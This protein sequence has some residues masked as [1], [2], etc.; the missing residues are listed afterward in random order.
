MSARY[1]SRSDL[2]SRPAGFSVAAALLAFGVIALDRAHARGSIPYPG[3]FETGSPEDARTI[4]IT[5]ATIALTVVTLLA[6]LTFVAMS[7]ANTTV[8]PRQLRAFLRDRVTQYTIATFIGSFVYCLV[9]LLFYRGGEQP[10]APHLGAFVAL[11]LALTATGLLIAYLHN[12]TRAVQPNF[13]IVRIMR[14]LSAATAHFGQARSAHSVNCALSDVVV[15]AVVA[16]FPPPSRE[17][18]AIR[19]GYVQQIVHDPLVEVASRHN[20]TIRFRVRPGHFVFVGDPIADVWEFHDAV[21]AAIDEHF[22]IGDYRTLAQDLE[23]GIDQL[24]EIAIRALSPA[25]NDTFT[26]LACI[27]WLGDAVRQ[28]ITADAG[29]PIHLDA[30]GILRVIDRPLSFDSVVTAAFTKIRQSGATNAAVL[31]RLLEAV[32]RLAAHC[33]ATQRVPLLAELEATATLGRATGTPEID[34]ATIARR[35]QSAREA[36]GRSALN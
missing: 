11:L 24:V 17:V 16:G 9:V 3:I 18:F 31:L 36:L 22:D 28:F 30:A 5:V 34:A 25:I 6:S 27:D 2:W 1:R 12:L 26:A 20:S 10:M 7:F 32:E 19:S 35:A 29:T 33:T 8:G 21:G 4:L 13:V 14:E 15:E 23:F